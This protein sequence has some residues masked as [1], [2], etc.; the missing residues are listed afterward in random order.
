M[1]TDALSC[2]HEVEILSFMELISEFLA[3]LQGKCEHDLVYGPVWT[4]VKRRDTSPSTADNAISTHDS[5]LLSDKLNQWKNFPLIK[6]TYSTKV[7]YV[8]H[9]M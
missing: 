1:V 3:S 5:P 7:E 9:R 8:Y 6:G 4:M 2:M